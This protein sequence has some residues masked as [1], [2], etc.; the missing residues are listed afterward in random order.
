MILESI[1]VLLVGATATAVG[2]GV[3]TLRKAASRLKRERDGV[4]SEIGRT[5][6]VLTSR[7][8]ALRDTARGYLDAQLE[9]RLNDVKL[10]VLRDQTEGSVKV[11]PLEE[12]GYQSVGD[13]RGKSVR[14]LRAVRGI[15]PHSADAIAR[16]VQDYEREARATPPALPGADLEEPRATDL[17]RDALVYLE[18]WRELGSAPEEMDASFEPLR[19]RTEQALKDAG[20]LRWIRGSGDLPEELANLADDVHVFRHD[21]DFA[22]AVA[23]RDGLAPKVPDEVR[24][25]WQRQYADC[26]ALIEGI[27]ADLGDELAVTRLRAPVA[28]PAPEQ[29]AIAERVEKHPLDTTGLKLIL[30]RYQSFGARYMLALERTVLGDEMGLGKTIQALA[31]AVH[32][33]N[34]TDGRAAHFLVVAPASILANWVHEIEARTPLAARLLHGDEF[35]QVLHAWKSDGGVAV[36]SYTTLRRNADALLGDGPGR[37]DLLIADEAHYVKNPKAGRTKALVS[38]SDRADKVCF[39][40]GTPLENH[41]EEFV[42]LLGSLAPARARDLDDFLRRPGAVL[43]GARRFHAELADVYLRRNQDD[44]LKELPARLEKEEW[45]DLTPDGHNAYREAVAAGNFMGMR[46]AVTG[47][48]KLER[49]QDL[50]S[51]YRESGVKVLL[52]SYFLEVLQRVGE[53][54][55]PIGAITGSVPPQERFELVQR[56]NAADEPAL[57]VAQIDAGG[58]GLNLQAA[59]AVVIMEPQLKP[60]TEMQAIARAHRMGQTRRVVVHRLLA[61][62]S[63]DERLVEILA[64]KQDLFERFA[65][66][67]V[68]KDASEEATATTPAKQIIEAERQRLA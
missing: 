57:L 18:A 36:T 41:P 53:R 2:Y 43:G 16:A 54:F 47:E 37:L 15:G 60:T 12:A 46:R 29:R 8:K 27:F 25:Q 17:A 52:F 13:L 28:G 9:A 20:F 51:E 55:D 24:D 19:E 56:F 34:G 62:D 50:L 32:I 1:A 31:A 68:I 66:E 59:G 4:R 39:M 45:I 61:R 10:D 44:V 63:V 14:D 22:E 38:V 30:R 49:L 21:S 11:A 65:R 48:A 23:A 26:T 3:S 35:E 58:T 7:D 6:G 64:E 33:H 42:H 67:S 40:S 5:R